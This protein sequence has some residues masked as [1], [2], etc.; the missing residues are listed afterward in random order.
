[1]EVHLTPALRQRIV[2]SVGSVRGLNRATVQELVQVEGVD[3]GLALEMFKTKANQRGF[4]WSQAAM[5]R[6]A[7]EEGTRKSAVNPYFYPPPFLLGM[8]WF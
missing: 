2:D 8:S 4:K 3:N 5:S 7:H 1:M 6:L